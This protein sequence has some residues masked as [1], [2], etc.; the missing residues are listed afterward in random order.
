MGSI[1]QRW[2]SNDLLS[3][4]GS[5]VGRVGGL[6]DDLLMS[7]WSSSIG[8][9]GSGLGIAGVSGLGIASVC[10]LS[11]VGGVSG[12]CIRQSLD[13]GVVDASV[14]LGDNRGWAH[15]LLGDLG[16]GATVSTLDVLLRNTN[17]QMVIDAGVDSA[18]AVVHVADG[19]GGRVG[20]SNTTVGGLTDQTGIDGDESSSEGYNLWNRTKLIETSNSILN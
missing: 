14:T 12:L 15:D 1:G 9:V 13:A 6:S 18:I 19:W 11:S 17:R 7:N 5:S 10:G 20:N 3:D 4:W 2:L 8:G 16:D